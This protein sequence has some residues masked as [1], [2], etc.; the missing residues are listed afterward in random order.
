MSKPSLN[1]VSAIQC[2][3]VRKRC[4]N[5]NIVGVNSLFRPAAREGNRAI[6]PSRNFQKHFESAINVFSCWAK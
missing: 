2:S 1:H 4:R 6:T 3:Q 5:A